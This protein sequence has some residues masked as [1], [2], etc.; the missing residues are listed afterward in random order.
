[1]SCFKQHSRYKHRQ[2]LSIILVLALFFGPSGFAFAAPPKPTASAL[3]ITTSDLSYT[4]SEDQTLNFKVD[5]TLT[6]AINVN[7][8]HAPS[9]DI[10]LAL[11]NV[12]KTSK[13]VK[14]TTTYYESA[15]YTF[16][17]QNI[18]TTQT[19]QFS[20]K[21]QSA[22]N[23]SDTDTLILT[24]I[25]NPVI[26]VTPENKPPLAIHDAYAAEV[27]KKLTFNPLANDSDPDGDALQLISVGPLENLS[28]V[29]V[30]PLN[31]NGAKQVELTPSQSQVGEISLNYVVS[32][33]KLE[34]T[35]TIAITVTAP[36]VTVP[37]RYVALGDSI[38]NGVSYE[39][40]TTLKIIES[41]TDKIWNGLKASHPD[42]IYNDHS[43]S[44]LKVYNASGTGTGSSL[45]A[46]VFGD[47]T[48]R[49]NLSKANLVTICIGA[50]DIM[51]AAAVTATGAIDFYNINW[52]IADLG[53]DNF[54]TYWDDI[55]NEIYRLN[56]TV[57]LV[58]MNMYNPYRPSDTKRNST[59]HE[60]Y[61][62]DLLHSLVNKYFYSTEDLNPSK[63][64]GV[65]YGLNYIIENPDLAYAG[66]LQSDGQTLGFVKRYRTVNVY[67][68][69]ETDQSFKSKLIAFYDNVGYLWGIFPVAVQDPHPTGA[70]QGIL[71][72]LHRA[73]LGW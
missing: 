55:V 54:Y 68:H 36:V 20:I 1:M 44:G 59:A 60:V 43:V 5:A 39:K 15:S 71:F 16:T 67:Q 18:E 42:A 65:D 17:P 12:T 4:I 23:A 49:T 72:D 61:G 63:A 26:I 45:Y 29:P 30:D 35:G 52:S 9:T 24:V 38:P 58:V 19:Y 47:S 64:D 37:Y 50:N 7:W 46:Q 10:Q 51:D 48:I 56:P 70:G 41:Y 53:L 14:R 6:K 21:A 3:N 57:D 62:L 66:Q 31:P 8:T 28:I 40:S 32:D 27:G 13:T 25:V 73:V 22:T 33:G 2:L 11:G 34:S 69:F